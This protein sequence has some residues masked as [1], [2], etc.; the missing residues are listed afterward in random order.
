MRQSIDI[1]GQIQTQFESLQAIGVDKTEIKLEHILKV[2]L[3][4]IAIEK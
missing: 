4:D 3:G 1:L 2:V